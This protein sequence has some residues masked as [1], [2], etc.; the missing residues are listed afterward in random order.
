MNHTSLRVDGENGQ[1]VETEHKYFNRFSTNPDATKEKIRKVLDLLRGKLYDVPMIVHYRSY[2]YGN[3]L[4]E[5][6]I[7]IIYNLDQEYGKFTQ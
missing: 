2:E 7:W 3:E 5:E 1:R 4:D 6:S